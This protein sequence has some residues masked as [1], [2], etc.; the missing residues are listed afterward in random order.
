MQESNCEFSIADS[1]SGC[2]V[3]NNSSDSDGSRGS[4]DQKFEARIRGA[5]EPFDYPSIL[6]QLLLLLLHSTI[7]ENREWMLRM[8]REFRRYR[9]PSR[10][11][12]TCL[13]CHRVFT[14]FQCSEF[15]AAEVAE[16]R[17]MRQECKGD[18]TLAP[19]SL[20]SLFSN[21]QR[22]ARI[23]QTA[24]LEFRSLSLSLSFL[25]LASVIRRKSLLFSAGIRSLTSLDYRY[26]CWTFNWR[27]IDIAVPFAHCASPMMTND[28][29]NGALFRS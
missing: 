28:E 25:P 27:L 9:F 4:N 24:M 29:R 5:F 8:V 17:S 13:W 6:D 2:Y 19:S 3:L 10:S 26:K 7:R 1:N 18:E 12:F 20:V 16:A 23:Y 11:A 21:L 15:R 22:R 14:A